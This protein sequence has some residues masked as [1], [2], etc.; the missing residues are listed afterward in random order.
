MNAAHCDEIVQFFDIP[1]CSLISVLPLKYATGCPVHTYL[2]IRYEGFISDCDCGQD[3]G[4]GPE[5]HIQNLSTA[6]NIVDGF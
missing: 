5:E 4:F 3:V 1:F 6:M 2:D